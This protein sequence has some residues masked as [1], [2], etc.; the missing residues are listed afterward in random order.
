MEFT[1]NSGPHIINT[2]GREALSMSCQTWGTYRE[3]QRRAGRGEG[4]GNIPGGGILF[5]LFQMTKTWRMY[6]HDHKDSHVTKTHNQ[7]SAVM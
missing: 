2:E 1:I 7:K 6:V 5:T 4:E 3:E